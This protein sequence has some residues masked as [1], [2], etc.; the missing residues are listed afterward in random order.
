MSF[1]KAVF[2]WIS[3]LFAK[4]TVKYNRLRKN[5]LKMETEMPMDLKSRLNELRNALSTEPAFSVP[6]G[7]LERIL[8][9]LDQPLRVMVMG[10]FST[11]KSSFINAL[12]GQKVAEVD[13]E[14]T[15]AVITVFSYGKPGITVH[16]QDGSTREIRADEF[17]KFTSTLSGSDR[18]RS[19]VRYVD[20]HVEHPLL[21]KLTLI[22]SPGLNDTN[23]AR[24]KITQEFLS[25]AEAVL[26]MVDATQAAKK[27]EVDMVA[28]LPA[29]L[30][31][32]VI[33]NKVDMIDP[34]EEGYDE[35]EGEAA[36]QGMAA[37]VQE[38]F[39]DIVRDVIPVSAKYT[40]EGRKRKSQA[41]EA[42]G[43]IQS[44]LASL[45]QDYASE[46]DVRRWG[47]VLWQL[48]PFTVEFSRACRE[49]QERIRYL[50]HADVVQYN[51]IGLSIHR[52]EDRVGSILKEEIT[53]AQK[54]TLCV[55]AASGLEMAC[56]M[57]GVL[58]DTNGNLVERTLLSLA[59][60]QKEAA[61]L[62]GLS[63]KSHHTAGAEDMLRK[64]A[65]QGSVD[66]LAL[67]PNLTQRAADLGNVHAQAT[68]GKTETAY[69]RMAAEQKEPEAVLLWAWH[70]RQNNSAAA[71]PWYELAEAQHTPRAF[72][73]L[74]AMY[75][76]GDGVTRDDAKAYA[77]F[78][79]AALYPEDAMRAGI[80]CALLVYH[81]QGVE[82]NHV[83]AYTRLKQLIRKGSEQAKNVF[84]R[85]FVNGPAVIQIEIGRAAAHGAFSESLLDRG[86]TPCTWYKRAWE[87]GNGEGAY[88]YAMEQRSQGHLF[89][90]IDALVAASHLGYES[91]RTEKDN[92]IRTQ[93]EDL[94]HMQ[95]GSQKWRT[96]LTDAETLQLPQAAYYLGMYYEEHDLEVALS[97]FE[98]AVSWGNTQDAKN[99]TYRVRAKLLEREGAVL[100][101]DG[102]RFQ[103]YRKYSEAAA[104]YFQ[105]STASASDA[106]GIHY[107][108]QKKELKQELL[109]LY[110]WH[111]IKYAF[112]V[113]CVWLAYSHGA[114]AK[115]LLQQ[116]YLEKAHP[117]AVLVGVLF[118]LAVCTGQM[119]KNMVVR[120]FASV[121]YLVTFVA[122][123]YGAYCYFLI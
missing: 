20:R 15:T 103:A 123:V 75:R 66:A 73:Q 31:P 94:C 5:K 82:Q 24:V 53:Q 25:E 77:Y 117:A 85:L 6:Q 74:G 111:P 28:S 2:Y 40:L 35:D 87:S 116:W 4:K 83:A 42:E 97:H 49:L 108:E 104:T 16:Y 39:G 41:M 89:D 17:Q 23:A 99:A 71:I 18:V 98:K 120:F 21:R 100:Y 72:F 68:L 90:A 50:Y 80:E 10:E 105:M 37:E 58:P 122:G 62:L 47:S 36:I 70:V 86:E 119:R 67:L 84:D 22:D 110:V 46:K 27:N 78:T 102:H 43:N 8:A 109:H 65:Q 29:Y 14:P 32:L 106:A 11:G 12:L 63:R 38:K 107:L 69:L 45:E 34:E 30:K 44:V 88:L 33:L 61:Y 3:S 60:H 13:S 118:I 92:L 95:R 76:D 19:S 9:S 112:L 121:A 114:Q 79:R 52:V 101:A 54:N 81:G 1:A 56:R 93:I 57:S 64:A 91:A 48:C 26:W 59:E 113:L 115:T 7:Y 51:R 55:Q 96:I